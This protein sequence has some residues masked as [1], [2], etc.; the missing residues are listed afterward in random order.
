MLFPAIAAALMTA[1]L[2]VPSADDIGAQPSR[3]MRDVAVSTPAHAADPH[4]EN[5][6]APARRINVAMEDHKFSPNVFDV[7]VGD[8]VTF[9]FTNFGKAAHD[10]FIGD[11]AAQEQHEKEMRKTPEG[12][13]HGHEH[14]H[15][16]GIAVP[17]GESGTL[18]YSFDKVGT[19]EIGCH[20]PGHYE[21]DM[22]A[23]VDVNPA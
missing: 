2:T 16:G 19:L 7:R 15:E 12:H 17:P 18:R 13:K 23:V 22:I 9:V 8:T 20:Q 3:A 21:A 5:A 14:A 1:A 10:A 6:A 4:P 11:K